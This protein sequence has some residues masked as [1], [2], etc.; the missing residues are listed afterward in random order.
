MEV[1]IVDGSDD[2]KKAKEVKAIANADPHVMLHALG[3]N[4]H[5][6]P[7]L[8]YG[9]N[10]IKHDYVF[11]I[12]TDDEIVN[13][14]IFKRMF[15]LMGEK[16]YAVGSMVLVD[17]DCKPRSENRYIPYIYP[18]G[19]LVNRNEFFK[20]PL[21][22]V[23]DGPFIK[24]MKAIF[25]A[26]LSESVLRHFPGLDGVYIRRG[27]GTTRV[28]TVDPEKCKEEWLV[29]K[30]DLLDKTWGSL[31]TRRLFYGRP[32]GCVLRYG[33]VLTEAF[34][35]DPP[36]GRRGVVIEEYRDTGDN[37]SGAVHFDNVTPQT[38]GDFLTDIMNT[39]ITSWDTV[40]W[41]PEKI[42]ALSAKGNTDGGVDVCPD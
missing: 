31:S 7:G 39:L 29:R 11:M 32:K 30:R 42:K 8:V 22:I 27:P 24:T 16:T 19:M 4:I 2:R 13:S 15:E 38:L 21:P 3:H 14:D 41:G 17:D 12:D 37:P 20:Y 35:D 18:A 23:H 10:R 34:K 40:G 5:H 33:I 1:V 36:R 9:M 25:K 28:R 26:G 6:G